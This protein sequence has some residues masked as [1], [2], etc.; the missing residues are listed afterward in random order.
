[1]SEL[2]RTGQEGAHL[3]ELLDDVVPKDVSHELVG[4]L[5]DLTEHHLPLR[6]GGALQL[7]LDKPGGF[8]NTHT[9]RNKHKSAQINVR[10]PK[11]TLKRAYIHASCI[12][13][14][15]LPLSHTLNPYI[16]KHKQ[17]LEQ[18]YMHTLYTRRLRQTHTQIHSHVKG[19]YNWD[20]HV[21]TCMCVF[22]KMCRE[23]STM[24][25]ACLS[26]LPCT[27]IHS[28]LTGRMGSLV[29]FPGKATDD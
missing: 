22:L 17:T 5:Q 26:V 15:F 28:R 29:Q 20:I 3:K 10:K 16:H 11:Q 13:K 7:L 1:M 6:W 9:Q 19:T 4:G 12:Y 25:S 27:R 8:K 14:F 23:S 24:K 2:G 18:A 21:F